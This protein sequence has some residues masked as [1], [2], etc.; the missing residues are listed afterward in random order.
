MTRAVNAPDPRAVERARHRRAGVILL[1]VCATLWSLN[2]ILVKVTS[3]DPIAFAGLRSLVATV[4]VLPFLRAF[5]GARPPAGV[6]SLSVLFHT[7]MVAFFIA[8]ITWGTAAAGVILQYTGPAWVALIAWGLQR[9]R[10]S[11]STWCAVALTCLG[12]LAMI[13]VPLWREP[14]FDPVGP[15]CGLAA[16]VA[17]GALIVMLEKTD[18]DAVHP[19][20]GRAGVNP[21]W[22]IGINNAGTAVLLLPAA[23]LTDRLHLTQGQLG[24]IAFCGVVQHALPYLLFQLG[25][26]RVTAVEAS[27][28]VL[29]E[30]ILSPTWVALFWGEMPTRWDIIGGSAILAALLLVAVRRSPGSTHPAVAD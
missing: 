15:G 12:V 14:A 25:L 28:L 13:A 20:T 21:I 4:A 9:R 16:G 23:W 1:L 29:L 11:A 24:L 6:M 10:L 27:L 22:V 3:A 5:D 8:A 30:P 7:L 19:V 18:R 26:R 2:G 17:F